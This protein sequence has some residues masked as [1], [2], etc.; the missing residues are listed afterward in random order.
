MQS[1]NF[2]ENRIEKEEGDKVERR[3]ERER[4]TERETD[5]ERERET[6]RERKSEMEMAEYKKEH[7]SLQLNAI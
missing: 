3:G 7:W 4:E 1:A 2:G 5:K 6:E